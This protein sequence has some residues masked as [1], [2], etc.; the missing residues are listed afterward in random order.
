[1]PQSP[2][3]FVALHSDICNSADFIP[4]HYISVKTFF[5]ELS[6]LLV[7]GDFSKAL[8][9]CFIVNFQIKIGLSLMNEYVI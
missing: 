6:F 9:H 3:Q 1:M 7:E 2:D 5:C 8:G 4:N